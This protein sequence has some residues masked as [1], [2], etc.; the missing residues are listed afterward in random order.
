MTAYAGIDVS[1]ATLQIALFP[2]AGELSVPNTAEG[3][4]TLSGWLG[5]RQVLRVLIEA[6][7]GYEKLSVRLLAKTGFKVQRINPFRARQFAQAMGKRA[8]TDPIDARMLATFAS[9]LE[10]KDFV[11]PD[12]DRDKLTELVNQRDVFI[13]QRDDNRRR[14]QQS[15]EADVLDAYR[16]L[17]AKL[18]EM[19]AATDKRIAAQSRQIDAE[20]MER[21]RSIKGVGPVTISSL[22][23][24]LPELGDLSRGQVAAL[25]GVAPYNNDSGAKRGVRRIYG[26]RP[27][28]RRAVYMS[29]LVMVRHNDD[30]KSRY[31]RLRAAGKCPKVALVA[32]MR[33]L[34]VR[35]NAMVRDGKPWQDPP[36]SR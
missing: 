32:C 33:V 34:L 24:Y 3:L 13:Q 19:I 35:L 4:A 25:A 22:F 6:T 16:E 29:T 12:G 27:K 2:Q 17:N 10:E 11:F 31:A 14:I 28:L 21:L 23:C 8:K 1:K 9:A 15:Q 20:L 30:F 36:A 5:E 7:G 26:G 18:K